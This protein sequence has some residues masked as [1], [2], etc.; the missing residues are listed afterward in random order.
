M[1]GPLMIRPLLAVGLL[2]TCWHATATACDACGS[3]VQ[4]TPQYET[5]TVYEREWYTETKMVTTLQYRY[6]KRERTVTVNR[7]VP[8]TREVTK[9]YT[10]MVPETRT[11]EVTCTV[12][13]PETRTKEV[14]CTVM[15]PEKRTREETY[16]E[17]VPQWEEV[18]Q[19]YTVMVPYKEDVEQT[20]TVCVPVTKVVQQTCTVMV[21]HQETRQGTRRICK[22]V[23]VKQ[24]RTITRDAGHW[25]NRTEEVS[26]T[27]CAR[28]SSCGGCGGCGGC[29]TACC[30]STEPCTKTVTR[31]VWVPKLVKENVTCTVYKQQIVEEPCEYTVTVM[32]PETRTKNVS[33][34][35][36]QRETRT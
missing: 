3:T 28:V 26:M 29:A 6:E 36:Y 23:P 10:V 15:V 34:T 19:Q 18:E 4:C 9:R 8:E 14:T 17:M 35:S 13:V 20:Y 7:R 32:K 24:T 1:S 21:P 16:C 27:C 31:R 33:V 11:K 22:T 2:S 25:E 30:V 12:M 5:R